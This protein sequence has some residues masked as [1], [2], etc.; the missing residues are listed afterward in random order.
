MEEEQFFLFFFLEF[1][2]VSVT[3]ELEKS[4]LRMFLYL[5]AF[6]GEKRNYIVVVP[7]D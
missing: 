7:D 2:L 5:R 3:F 1:G 4:I 6:D